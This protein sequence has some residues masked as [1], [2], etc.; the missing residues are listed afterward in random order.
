MFRESDFKEHVLHPSYGPKSTPILQK[1]AQASKLEAYEYE[2]P[3]P[4]IELPAPVP[5]THDT[6]YDPDD[7]NADW[8]VWFNV[9]INKKYIF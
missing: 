6:I 4:S 1:I 8:A 2:N 5:V 7:P 3:K 9:Y